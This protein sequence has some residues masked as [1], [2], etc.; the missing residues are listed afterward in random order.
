MRYRDIL[1]EAP[2]ALPPLYPS[3]RTYKQIQMD[4]SLHLSYP[5]CL[6]HSQTE[7]S[8]NRAAMG[9][10]FPTILCGSLSRA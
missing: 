3:L 7:N 10:A 9:L 8:S 4:L 1:P 2:P 5:K 6:L